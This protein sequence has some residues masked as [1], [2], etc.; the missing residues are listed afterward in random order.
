MHATRRTAATLGCLGTC[1]L[2][3]FGL[4][5]RAA[6]AE[7]EDVLQL[8]A[9]TGPAGGDLTITILRPRAALTSTRSSMSR[10]G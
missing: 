4:G 6:A 8:T 5:G 7:G 2:V 9:L 10:S 1:V 3:A